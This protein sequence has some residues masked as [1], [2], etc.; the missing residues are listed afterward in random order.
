MGK[1]RARLQ[2]TSKAQAKHMQDKGKG[3]RQLGKVTM[4]GQAYANAK[5][6]QGKYKVR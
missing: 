1:A 6:M 5:Q 2:G 3:L 4:Q